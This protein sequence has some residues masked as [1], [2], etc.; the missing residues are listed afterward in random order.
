[1]GGGIGNNIQLGDIQEIKIGTL[2]KRMTSYYLF[3]KKIENVFNYKISQQN[4]NNINI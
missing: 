3:Q 4:N 2:A 1:M